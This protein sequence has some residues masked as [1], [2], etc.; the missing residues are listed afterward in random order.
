MPPVL[1]RS[2]GTAEQLPLPHQ[3]RSPRMHH[4]TMTADSELSSERALE[5][6][7]DSCP[8]EGAATSAADT[9]N[10]AAAGGSGGG[11][12]TPQ[13][14]PPP[15]SLDDFPK[16]QRLID[17]HRKILRIANKTPLSV[18][19]EYAS[20]LNVEVRSYYMRL[21]SLCYISERQTLTAH[22]SCSSPPDANN[23]VRMTCAAG[24]I[25]SKPKKALS[26]L[27]LI[28]QVTSILQTK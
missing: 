28:A 16:C 18:L 10:P 12:G 6:S 26:P 21:A 24:T 8:S 14:Q 27:H 4:R 9:A 3:Q 1:G 11:G 5:D 13:P 19:H 2:V 17:A 20:R 23:T 15:C 22:F 25:P 7:L